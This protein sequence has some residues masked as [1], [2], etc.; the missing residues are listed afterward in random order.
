MRQ[1]GQR[2]WPGGSRMG[3]GTTMLTNLM[4]NLINRV[5]KLR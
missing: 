1:D 3:Q 5:K 2:A 4:L